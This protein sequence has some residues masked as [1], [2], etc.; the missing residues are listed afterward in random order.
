MHFQGELDLANEA[1][2]K[3]IKEAEK[4]KRFLSIVGSKLYKRK[5]VQFCIKIIFTS[6]KRK[7]KSSIL[8]SNC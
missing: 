4:E 6:K 1:F 5:K 3:A 8:Y 7:F 2:E